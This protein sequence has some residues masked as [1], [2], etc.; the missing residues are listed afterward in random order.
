MSQR[1]GAARSGTTFIIADDHPVFRAGV[2]RLLET[3][4]GYQVL[5]ETATA[6]ETVAA[7]RSLRPDI[8]LL[9]L[10]MPNGNGFT[11]LARSNPQS[12]RRSL[13]V[14]REHPTAGHSAP[15][16]ISITVPGLCEAMLRIFLA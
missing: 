8:L 4:P 16:R 6:P 5:A 15:V 10:A 2:R 9:D 11:V 7:G 12:C 13:P 3:E 1:R 14:S